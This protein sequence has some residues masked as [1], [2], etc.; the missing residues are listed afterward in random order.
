MPAGVTW[1]ASILPDRDTAPART[2]LLNEPLGLTVCLLR[3]SL[4]AWIAGVGAMSFMFGLI[5]KTAAEAFTGSSYLQDLFNSLGG[6]SKAVENYLGIIF[7]V[8]TTLVAL[9]AAAQVSATREEEAKGYLDNLLV[10]LVS[11]ARWLS[12]RVLAAMAGL[13]VLGLAAGA[14]A[15]VGT[16]A[17]D[18]GVTLTKLLA[19]GLNTVPPG[20]LVLG[21]GTMVH[22][23]LPLYASPLA[24]GLI[25][26][27]FL[28]EL[29]GSM[30]K[31]NHYFLDLS[32][33]HHMA[34]APAAEIRWDSAAIFV[35]F[36]IGAAVLGVL[37][38]NRRD[39]AGL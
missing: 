19:T 39:L 25:A 27:S 3:G 7:F 32:I 35:G 6:R 21:L 16:Y 12:E 29:V 20:I 37:F 33:F 11:R 18:S 4:A 2:G 5:A 34:L 31:A 8:L 28:V 17:Q 1:A 15:W 36:G 23:L 10:R 24:Y 14:I 26:W 9:Y 30:V 22:G 13:V 38:F